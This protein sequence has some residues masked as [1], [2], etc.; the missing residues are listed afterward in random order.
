MGIGFCMTM[1]GLDN[2]NLLQIKE[3]EHYHISYSSIIEPSL[4]FSIRMSKYSEWWFD[5]H[6]HF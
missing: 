3:V 1:Y 5:S 2:V 6:Y 4:K